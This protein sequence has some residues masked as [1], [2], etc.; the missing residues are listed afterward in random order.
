[1]TALKTALKSALVLSLGIMVAPIFLFWY[2]LPWTLLT[3]FAGFDARTSSFWGQAH[4]VPTFAVEFMAVVLYY[5][6]TAV[7]IVYL[8]KLV[9][10]LQERRSG[11]L[12]EL[13]APMPVATT[14]A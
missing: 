9:G 1:M 3:E 5:A 8:R 14:V 10:F 4:P 11:E 13:D 2:M 6:L 7:I 12:D